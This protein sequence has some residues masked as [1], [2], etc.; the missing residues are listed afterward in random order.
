MAFDLEAMKRKIAALLAKANNTAVTEAEADA[1]NRK[2]HELMTQYN[3]GRAELDVDEKAVERIH[4][5][6]S[7]QLRPWSAYILSGLTKLYY[8]RYFSQQVGRLH[9]ITIIGEKQ[10]VHVCHAIAVMVLRSV[11]QAA[12]IDGG[13]RSFMTGAGLEIARRCAEMYAA[14]HNPLTGGDNK[15]HQISQAREANALIILA[16]SEDDGNQDYIENKMG[17]HLRQR[18]STGAKVRNAAAFG[19]GI[20][21]GK[22]VQLRRNLLS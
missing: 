11:Q 20:A 16:R 21:H 17:I 12:R 10:N 2:A 13:G 15:T 8:C 6:L 9:E 22:T 5:V 4:T 19:A 1:F 14:V 18:R 3:V 7:V